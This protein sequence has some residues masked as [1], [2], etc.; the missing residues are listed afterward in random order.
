MD[1]NPDKQQDAQDHASTCCYRIYVWSS[2]RQ[3][4]FAVS[5]QDLGGWRDATQAL[6][7]A[8]Y[9]DAELSDKQLAVSVRTI[10]LPK[11]EYQAHKYCFLTM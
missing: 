6:L 8:R 7:Q 9:S 2:K 3:H 4:I 11:W 5:D 10:H 1:D